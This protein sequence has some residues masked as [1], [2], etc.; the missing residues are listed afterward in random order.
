MLPILLVTGA[1]FAVGMLVGLAYGKSLINAVRRSMQTEI[2]GLNELIALERLRAR[3]RPGGPAEQTMEWLSTIP[4]ALM[5]HPARS[6]TRAD[7]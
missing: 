1:T 7:H 6:S 3:K 4:G 2:D 5:T